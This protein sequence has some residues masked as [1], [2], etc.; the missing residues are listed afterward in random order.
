[1]STSAQPGRTWPLVGRTAELDDLDAL[2]ASTAGGEGGTVLVE[3]EA[4]IGR[5][6]LVEAL[7]SSA[8]LL[9]L[10]LRAARATPDRPAPFALLAD[11]LLVHPPGVARGPVETEL[12]DLLDALHADG[13]SVPAAGASTAQR[14][15]RAAELFAAL[16]RRRGDSSPWV[17]VLEDVHDA[18]A[19]SL[20]VLH[21]LAH[22]G[23]VPRA[24]VVLTMRPVPSRAVLSTVVD[25]WV[26][27]GAR[28][29]ELRPL[30]PLATVEL[31]ERLV[32]GSVGP[33]LRGTLA[34]TGGNPRLVTDVVRTA[35]SA[36]ALEARDGVVDVQGAA[37]LPALDALVRSRLE[38][39]DEDVVDLLAHASVLGT[40]FVVT[41][42]AVL[43]GCPVPDCWRTLRVALAAGV[44]HARADRLVFRHDLVRGAL[45]SGL[46]ERRRRTMHARAAWTL[47][48][49]GAP[50]QIVAGHLERAR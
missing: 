6:G 2:L 17:L 21:D 12:L 39:L 4:G 43:S 3:G 11:A 8:H 1:M 20:G 36:G 41:D 19:A 27:A 16:L 50:T 31:A 38:Y 33:A 23:D 48:E 7:T 32:G 42:L 34:T 47:Q 25:A 35:R 15:H 24:L 22:E 9:S 44:V 29:L 49:A 40:S 46:D 13:R 14:H 18:D 10:E 26:R 45:Y 37:W 5:T 28:Y 30:G